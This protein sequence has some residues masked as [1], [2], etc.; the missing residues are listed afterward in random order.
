[1]EQGF[2]AL[3]VERKTGS[4]K[5]V[6]SGKA[7]NLSLLNFWQWS[8]SDLVNNA[9]RG[10]IAEFIVA[11]A[12]GVNDRVR[13]EW[14]A[15]DLKTKGGKRVEVKSAAYIQS[16]T[17]SKLSP[18][19]FDI[20]PTRGWEAETNGYDGILKR[21]ADVY[22]FCILKTEDQ[23]TV[24]PLNLDQ[25]VFYVLPTEVLNKEKP[26]QKTITLSSLLQFKPKKSTYSELKKWIEG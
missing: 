10:V 25:W 13:V 8:S 6:L 2:P 12:L 18:I 24:D 5:F 4:E 3:H 9:L 19:I 23:S 14:D 17:Q 21:Q 1:M 16:W 20:R 7:I 26:H 22:V 11:S 15:Y